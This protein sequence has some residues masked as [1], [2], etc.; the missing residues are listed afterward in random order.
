M[1]IA[2]TKS[3]R[4]VVDDLLLVP[5]GPQWSK[6]Y[7]SARDA[8]DAH[9]EVQELVGHSLGGAVANALSNED[10]VEARLY[11]A[12]IQELSPY[13]QNKASIF[14]PIGGITASRVSSG[15][16]SWHGHSYHNIADANKRYADFERSITTPVKQR[17]K[18]ENLD[19]RMTPAKRSKK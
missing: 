18:F 8:L 9:P 10:Q 15:S 11:S 19:P 6:R 17:K 5:A 13:A 2:G 16:S 12:P 1:Y 3:P 4:D 7:K 14:D